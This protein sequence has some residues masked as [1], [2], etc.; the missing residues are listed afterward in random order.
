MRA[1]HVLDLGPQ[2]QIDMTDD[3][4][5]GAHVA[6][7][8]ARRHRG[9]AIHELGLTDGT[10]RLGS[11]GA[12]HGAAFQIDGAAHLVAAVQ[13]GKQLVEQV[14]PDVADDVHETVIGWRQVLQQLRR[15]IPQMMMRIDD[16]EIG[17]E[18][19]LFRLSHDPGSSRRSRIRGA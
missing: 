16:R 4:R 1:E 14:A 6:V 19:L 17:L 12:V 7:E 8:T 5:A 9:D 2:P 3:P 11:V 15:T 10:Q 18:D 13:V